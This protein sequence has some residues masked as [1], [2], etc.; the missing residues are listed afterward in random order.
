[1]VRAAAGRHVRNG[2]DGEDG[3]RAGGT[4]RR[5]ARKGE[6]EDKD[7]RVAAGRWGTIL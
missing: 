2:E 7:A 4:A 6:E 3:W 5:S 1:M